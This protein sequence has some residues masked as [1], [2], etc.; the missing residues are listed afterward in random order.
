MNRD[1]YVR[2]LLIIISRFPPSL[3][4]KM[5][6]F[7]FLFFSFTTVTTITTTKT[8]TTTTTF[9]SC[10]KQK[11]CEQDLKRKTIHTKNN[12]FYLSRH[13]VTLYS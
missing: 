11:V 13:S 5:F 3:R 10:A 2:I 9:S 8:K 6:F 12:I 1:F 4:E 7:F